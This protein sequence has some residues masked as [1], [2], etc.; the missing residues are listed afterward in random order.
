MFITELDSNDF[1]VEYFFGSFFFSRATKRAEVNKQ[2]I[3][4]NERV[5]LSKLLL[6][7]VHKQHKR[8]NNQLKRADKQSKKLYKSLFRLNNKQYYTS[9]QLKELMVRDSRLE[10]VQKLDEVYYHFGELMKVTRPII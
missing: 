8:V 5:K 9:H 1:R 6:K 2:L 4:Y 7:Q 3:E 10:L